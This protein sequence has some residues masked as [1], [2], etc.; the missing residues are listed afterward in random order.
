MLEVIGVS[1][2]I[3]VPLAGI[4][5]IS[6]AIGVSSD[7]CILLI[8]EVHQ[9]WKVKPALVTVGSVPRVAPF[10]TVRAAGIGIPP[11]GS[12]VTVLLM[13]RADCCHLATKFI[14]AVIGVVANTC[15]PPVAAVHQP[16]K[17][18]PALVT[19]GNVPRAEPFRTVLVAGVGVPPLALKVTVLLMVVVVCCHLATRFIL[20]VTTVVA[21]TC[22][23][24]V[25]AVHQPWKE[26]FALVTVGSV[27]RVAPF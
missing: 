19:V 7:A 11:L 12:K 22:E 3:C 18:K 10:R 20:A 5:A 16:W 13:T 4:N 6:A 1:A 9:P 14:L 27:P 26:W 21:N 15:V 8:A 23:P 17:L 24:P 2:N 25:A